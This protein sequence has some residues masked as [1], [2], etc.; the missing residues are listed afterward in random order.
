MQ[1][2][3]LAHTLGHLHFARPE[4]AEIYM[5]IH[6][7]LIGIRGLVAPLCGMWLY[8]LLGWPVWL[9]AIAFSISSI[10]TY[11]SLARYER[12]EGIRA[13]PHSTG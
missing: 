6:V 7:S 12:R 3:W 1:P 5:G 10:L 11:A 13:N 8:N 9:I 2:N 4:Q